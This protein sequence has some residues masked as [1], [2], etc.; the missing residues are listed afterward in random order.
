MKIMAAANTSHDPE[1]IRK[2]LRYQ[3]KAAREGS[4][5]RE[6]ANRMTAEA[7]A[8]ERRFRRASAAATI[9]NTLRGPTGH[10][11]DRHL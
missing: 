11:L 9:P 5:N 8:I 4:P 10:D 2:A 7:Q 6:W 1:A 3:V